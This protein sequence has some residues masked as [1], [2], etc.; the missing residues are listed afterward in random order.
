[1]RVKEKTGGRHLLGD[2]HKKKG[3][4]LMATKGKPEEAS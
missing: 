4:K 1:M 2:G 3:P